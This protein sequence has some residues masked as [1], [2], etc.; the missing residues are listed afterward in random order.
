MDVFLLGSVTNAA[1]PA[2]K[3]M[4]HRNSNGASLFVTGTWTGTITVEV[5]LDGTNW[6][7][8]VDNAGN[9]QSGITGNRFRLFGG[10]VPYVRTKKSA[11]MTGQADVY[12]VF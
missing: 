9:A 7:T 4:G 8:A 6:F 10:N 3:A 1:D 2:A 12:L 5:S 11:T